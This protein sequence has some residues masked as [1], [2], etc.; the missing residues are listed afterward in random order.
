MIRLKNTISTKFGARNAGRILVAATL[1]SFLF[2]SVSLV[3]EETPPWKDYSLRELIGRLK[4]Y[5][6]AKVAQSLRG[7]YPSHQEQVWENQECSSPVPELPGPFFCGLLRHQVGANTGLANSFPDSSTSTPLSAGDTRT[8]S[9]SVRQGPTF[10]ASG[11]SGS[12]AEVSNGGP[13][14]SRS[15]SANAI[16]KEYKNIQ[17]YAGTTIAG[18]NVVRFDSGEETLRAFYLTNGQISHYEY[19]DKVVIFDWSGS[20]LNSIL[21]VRVDS[22]LR[23]LSGR[24][25]YFR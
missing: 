23:P 4:Y 9:G 6:F 15:L 13:K 14:V 7:N 16:P 1:F 22:G 19:R 3:A 2:F 12:S 17:L 18:K 11:V 24:E 25:F 10:S 8:D 5:T 20:R 21:E